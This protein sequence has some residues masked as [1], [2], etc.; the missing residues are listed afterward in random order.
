MNP[1]TFQE[2]ADLITSTVKRK[3]IA[4]GD[5]VN[6]APQCLA[7]L[8]PEGLQPHQ[9][10]DAALAVRLLDKIS[11]GL[12]MPPGSDEENPWADA[13]GYCLIRADEV[14]MEAE[15]LRFCRLT[16]PDATEEQTR[17]A[18]KILE[19]LAQHLG[20]VLALRI[21]ALRLASRLSTGGILRSRSR[22]LSTRNRSLSRP[23]PGCRSCRVKPA[24]TRSWTLKLACAGAAVRFRILK[25]CGRTTHS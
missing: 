9:Y 20:K 16:T 11:R 1:E 23:R 13:A 5:S 3:N 22:S 21:C 14:R 4:Y 19:R 10:R 2:T 7:I 12:T 8:A 18:D 17:E 24:T 25:T 15:V 6:R